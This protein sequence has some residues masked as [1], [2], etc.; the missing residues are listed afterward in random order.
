MPNI[1]LFNDQ[2]FVS[3]GPNLGLLYHVGI[4]VR[5]IDAA[6]KRFG[7]LFGVN[8]WRGDPPI[9]PPPPVQHGQQ[10]TRGGLRW[11]YTKGSFPWLELLQPTDDVAWSMT[12]FLREKGEGVHHLGYFVDDVNEAMRKLAD[13]GVGGVPPGTPNGVKV[14]PPYRVVYLDASKTHGVSF[15]LVD[16]SI[17]PTLVKFV[18]TGVW[19][20][21]P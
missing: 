8:E 13:F 20:P 9:P 2:D 11:A 3:K 7:E 18:T 10:P 16:Q 5:D 19:D 4:A 14:E 15:E 12:D 1:D 21:L 6:K 17:R